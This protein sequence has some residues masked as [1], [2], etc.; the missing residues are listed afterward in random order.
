MFLLAGTKSI[1]AIQH[2]TIVIPATP[3]ECPY[4]A[5][6]SKSG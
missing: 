3:A 5:E 2:S 6:P 1:N 4:N